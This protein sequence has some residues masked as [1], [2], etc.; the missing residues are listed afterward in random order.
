[1]HKD[2]LVDDNGNLITC[3]YENCNNTAYFYCGW[4]GLKKINQ[5]VGCC[6][7]C[8]EIGNAIKLLIK[9][10]WENIVDSL[11]PVFDP[12]KK[13]LKKC[14]GEMKNSKDELAS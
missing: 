2:A 7:I 3:K 10:N 1:M 12:I 11:P 4:K 6:A 14:V 13:H 9:S 5:K 8:T